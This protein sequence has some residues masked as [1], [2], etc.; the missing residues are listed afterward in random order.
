MCSPP[1]KKKLLLMK[2]LWY[3]WKIQN[4]YQITLRRD[5]FPRPRKNLGTVYINLC[6]IVPGFYCTKKQKGL[7][8]HGNERHSYLFLSLLERVWRSDMVADGKRDRKGELEMMCVMLVDPSLL[9]G[10]WSTTGIIPPPLSSST[11]NHTFTI[12]ELWPWWR[13]EHWQ[14]T[15]TTQLCSLS[16]EEQ[17]EGKAIH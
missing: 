3:D 15:K 1:L 13:R 7:L 2:I 12:S 11:Q 10:V 9:A 6:N 5:C 14:N 16:H 4:S 17:Q 8:N